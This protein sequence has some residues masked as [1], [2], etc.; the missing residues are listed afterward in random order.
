MGTPREHFK[1]LFNV[2]LLHINIAKMHRQGFVT[3]GLHGN[4]LRKPAGNPVRDRR[5]AE[6]MNH[7]ISNRRFFP[8]HLERGAN[9]LN[10]LAVPRKNSTGDIGDLFLLRFQLV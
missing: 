5:V 8:C 10:R 7:Q 4:L 3:G 9:A 6:I 1:S 2:V